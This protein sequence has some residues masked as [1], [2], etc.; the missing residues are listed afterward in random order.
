VPRSF[1][2]CFEYPD[3][4]PLLKCW[5]GLWLELSKAELSWVD[6]SVENDDCVRGEWHVAPLFSRRREEGRKSKPRPRGLGR[7]GEREFIRAVRETPEKI[8]KI[9]E[10]FESFERINFVG[11]SRM[12]PGCELDAHTHNNPDSLVMH[13]GLMIPEDES[14][15][16]VV[17]DT[18]FVWREPGDYCIFDDTIIHSAW[19][20]GQTDR[21][22]MHIDFEKE[23]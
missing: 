23:I 4:L 5:Q 20:K 8:P 12:F 15:S 3:L 18:E 13:I 11:L 1:Y 7:E 14:A 17:G 19:N 22:V 16:L 21:I 2:D 10:W 6:Y 9:V